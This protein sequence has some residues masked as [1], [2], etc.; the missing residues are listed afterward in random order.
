M[1]CTLKITY[2]KTSLAM[3]LGLAYTSAN[4]EHVSMNFHIMLCVSDTLRYNNSPNESAASVENI[5]QWYY[6]ETFDQGTPQRHSKIIPSL[7]VSP[8]MDIYMSYSKMRQKKVFLEERCPLI[9]WSPEDR[10][11]CMY[12]ICNNQWS[13]SM[14]LQGNI[15][16]LMCWL[17]WYPQ[18][19]RQL[20]IIHTKYG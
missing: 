6:S 2:F 7:E 20:Y 12:F 8:Q 1:L 14:C 13:Y 5:C 11:Y 19:P 9:R 17:P 4:N 3:L 18:A 10:Y 15:V 16:A